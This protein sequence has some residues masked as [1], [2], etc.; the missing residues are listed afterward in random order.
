MAGAMLT[1]THGDG[2]IHVEGRVWKKEDIALGNFFD[3]FGLTFTNS[4][5][6][7]K[8]N[9]DICPNGKSGTLKM[10]VNDQPNTDFR[11]YLIQ[12]IQDPQKQEIKIVFGP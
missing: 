7:Y 1:H 12:P 10:Y 3:G 11:D 4:S 6:I 9:G 8:K 5:I 2:V